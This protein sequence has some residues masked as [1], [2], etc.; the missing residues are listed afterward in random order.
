MRSEDDQRH[1][2]NDAEL[3]DANA[4]E[5][6]LQTLK[7]ARRSCPPRRRST[8]GAAG[9]R[10]DLD[11]PDLAACAAVAFQRL[12]LG[13]PFPFPER[14]FQLIVCRGGIEHL[15]NRFATSRESTQVLPATPDDQN[16]GRRL[17]PLLSRALTEPGPPSVSSG[18]LGASAA[19][20]RAAAILAVAPV[21]GISIRGG[22][23]M[24]VCYLKLKNWRNFTHVEVP[25][26][27]RQFFVGPNASGKSNLLDVFRFLRD[28]AKRRGGG[29][30]KAVGDRGGISKLRC[31]SAR[32]DPAVGITLALADTA[33]SDPPAWRYEI[34]IKQETR[35]SRRTLLSLE[36]VSK[37]DEILLER[38]DDRDKKDAERLT[39]TS[40]EQVNENQQF[41]EIAQFLEGITYL[42]LVPQLLRYADAFQGKQLE[43]DPFG[44][45]FLAKVASAS[46]T[47]RKPRL[48]HIQK[49][50]Q[51]LVPQLSELAF[52][53]D[54]ATGRP[55]LKARYS[56][57]RPYGSFQRE[58]QF[59]DGT[60]R[61]IGFS[62]ALLEGTSPLLLEEPE[63]SLHTRIVRELPTLIHRAQRR[64][65][66]Q[67]L[68]STHSAELLSDRGI[69][70]RE[71]LVLTPGNEGTRVEVA[72]D[73]RDVRALLEAGASVGEA[74]LSRTGSGDAID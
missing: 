34:E 52:E 49:G 37:R 10:A 53:R 6:D 43:D 59:S 39:Q 64:R 16:L 3:G 67:I 69:D 51:R 25:L 40:L 13:G 72:S 61:F 62:W 4:S 31:L 65:R 71:V 66:R 12:D 68:L 70:G 56:H 30:Q 7:N 46:E 47:T 26:R 29:L 15:E 1:G 41:R 63:L 36:R 11:A 33:D 35:G 18:A 19:V 14:R 22:E 57:W 27:E 50:V 28:I 38:P 21:A 5:H 73:L 24:L 45:G 9:W 58:D 44:Q 17:R 74:A 42:H 48:A 60:L 8:P 20:C 54:E 2:E 23:A 55:H 32:R